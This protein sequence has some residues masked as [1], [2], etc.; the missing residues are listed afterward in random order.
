MTPCRDQLAADIERAFGLAR[1]FG[2][3]YDLEII[4]GYPAQW[5]EPQVAGWLRDV[6][7]NMLGEEAVITGQQGMGAEDFSYMTQLAPGAMFGLGVK[8]PG[9]E[10]RYCIHRPSTSTRTPCP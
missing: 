1:A 7:G 10:P 4:R 6:A 3:D 9:G 5:N 2:G 8:A